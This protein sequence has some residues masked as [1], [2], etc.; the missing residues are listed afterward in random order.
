MLADR[1][2]TKDE[3]FA[4][5]ATFTLVAW[6][7]AYTFTV[8]QAIEPESFT[9][10]LDA[11]GDRTWM[12]LL[13]LSF[14][15]LTST[16]LSD[17]TPV[18]AFARGV[19][20]LEML[21][22]ARLRRPGGVAPGGAHRAPR[23]PGLNRRPAGSAPPTMPPPCLCVSP[24]P[25][26]PPPS[27]GGCRAR[28]RPRLPRRTWTAR[29]PRPGT[30]PGH[31]RSTPSR[32]RAP[33]RCGPVLACCCDAAPAARHARPGRKGRARP[34][35]PDRR[36]RPRPPSPHRCDRRGRGASEGHE[37]RGAPR[38]RREQPRHHRGAA[39][40]RPRRGHH[41]RRARRDRARDAHPRH[42][43]RPGQGRGRQRRDPGGRARPGAHPLRRPP[44]RAQRDRGREPQRDLHRRHRRLRRAR[45]PDSPGRRPPPGVRRARQPPAPPRRRRHRAPG[46]RRRRG[47]AQRGEPGQPARP[48]RSRTP[49]G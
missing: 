19:V 4:V 48:G 31:T 46:H 42:P 33:C 47:G 39:P 32:A 1:E 27:R 2:I 13:F 17:V 43:G 28:P 35:G 30:A 8:I 3:L 18:K 41:R 9:A 22:R 34:A 7:F 21:C 25:C 37:P 45:A 14:T 10:A 44:D 36:L 40:G 23:R 6:G 15:T 26:W 29:A 24:P 49:R 16:G 12:E 38:P 11:K 5:G 20:M